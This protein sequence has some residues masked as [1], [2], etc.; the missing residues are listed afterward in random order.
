[1]SLLRSAHFAVR[2]SESGGY[3][4]KRK[5]KMDARKNRRTLR[6]GRSVIEVI[7]ATTLPIKTRCPEKWISLDL[8][9]GDIWMGS[10]CGWRRA[11][12]EISR[13]AMEVMIAAVEQTHND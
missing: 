2:N 9:T 1:M 8:E 3:E 12:P 6:S 11:S 5:A 10:G 4:M 13:E 7:Q